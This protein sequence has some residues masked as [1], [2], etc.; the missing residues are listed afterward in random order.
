MRLTL[1]SNS[2]EAALVK[3]KGYEL[4]LRRVDDSVELYFYHP[5]LF[6]ACKGSH[7]RPLKNIMVK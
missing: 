4:F 1:N 5:F 6:V 7:I 3:N 2:R